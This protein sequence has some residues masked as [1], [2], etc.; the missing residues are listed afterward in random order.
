MDVTWH[1]PCPHMPLL[2][3]LVPLMQQLGQVSGQV[4]VHGPGGR[5]VPADHR[6]GQDIV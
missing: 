4:C 3:P 2:C 5:S 1:A 6:S